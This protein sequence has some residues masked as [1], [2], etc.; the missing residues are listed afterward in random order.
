MQAREDDFDTA[1]FF[2]GVLVD[3]HTPSIVTDGN[4]TVL[5][6]NH[7]NAR[8]MAGNGLV[9]TIINYLLDKVIGPAGVGVHARS[10]ANGLKTGKDL[11]ICGVVRFTQTCYLKQSS[12]SRQPRHLVV[13]FA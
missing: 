10:L 8:G 6:K 2:T 5:V 9:N 4:G 11:N 3:R 13:N 12:L 7:I 1:D